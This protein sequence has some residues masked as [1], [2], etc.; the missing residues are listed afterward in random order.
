MRV[1]VFRCSRFF[2]LA[3]KA[4][5]EKWPCAEIRAIYQPGS[6]RE[7][8]Q[9][10]L[11]LSDGI[12][13]SRSRFLTIR[14]FRRSPAYRELRKWGPDEIVI[15]WFNEAGEHHHNVTRLALLLKPGGFWVTFPDGSLR[16]VTFPE[17]LRARLKK[18]SLRSRHALSRTWSILRKKRALGPM[19]PQVVLVLIG[20]A[21]FILL[22]LS[23]PPLGYRRLRRALR[24]GADNPISP[25]LDGR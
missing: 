6:E 10:G 1:A 14:S 22:V 5:K 24:I 12:L 20:I 17:I 21:T 11:G 4:A 13:F 18:L 7:L 15:Q 19:I 2:V 3:I 16:R 25:A 23:L 9:A 8:A